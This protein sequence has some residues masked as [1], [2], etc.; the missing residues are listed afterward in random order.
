MPRNPP[1]HHPLNQ[2]RLDLIRSRAKLAEIFGLTRA[3]LAMERP[4]SKRSEPITRNGKTKVRLIQEPRGECGLYTYVSNA[5][6]HAT[7]KE[8]RKLDIRAYFPSTPGLL[9]FPYHHALQH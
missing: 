8:I 4:Y 5:A 9:V 1:K 3:G 6:Q 2:S 7:A